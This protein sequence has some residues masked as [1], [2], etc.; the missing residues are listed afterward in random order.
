MNDLNK[1]N[2]P[3]SPFDDSVFRMLVEH[4]S[5]ITMTMDARGLILYVNPAVR[6]LLGYEPGDLIGASGFEIIH[7][8][9]RAGLERTFQ[10]MVENPGRRTTVRHRINTKRGDWRVFETRVGNF[11][12]HPPISAV[13]CN[14][15]DITEQVEALDAMRRQEELMNQAQSVARLGSWNLDLRT[16]RMTWSKEMYRIFGFEPMPDPAPMD[17]AMQRVHPRDVTRVAQSINKC[18]QSPGKQSFEYRIL[19]PGGA[20][21]IV[22][23]GNQSEPGPHGAPVSMHGTL[24][25]ITELKQAESEKQ[26]LQEQ[27][28]HIQKL[29]AVGTLAGG[30]AHEFNNMLAVIMGNASL[31]LQDPDAA[32]A[33]QEELEEIIKASERSRDLA[34]KLLTFARRDKINVQNMPV[35]E[36][37]GDFAA[38]IEHSFPHNIQVHWTAPDDLR[39]SADVSQMRQVLLNLCN[40]ACDAMPQGGI[41]SIL[42]ADIQIF[43]KEAEPL[44]GLC[45]GR[46]CFITVRDSGMGIPS[47]IRDKIF[48][49]FFTTKGVG[50][51][52][53]LGLSIAHG[54]VQNHN[55]RMFVDN[56][57][58][59]G[60][61]VAFCLPAADDATTP[62]APPAPRPAANKTVLVVDDQPI[63][64]TLA[65]RIL[66]RDRFLVLT[67][68]TGAEAIEVFKH[69][70]GSIDLVL[71]DL[72][73]PDLDGEDVCDALL[74][75]DPGAAVLLCSGATQSQRC[76]DMLRKGGIAGLLKKPFTMESLIEAVRS[77][78]A[79]IARAT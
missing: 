26:A 74:D 30:I 37:L 47:S 40:N 67:A 49:P 63:M 2:T 6:Q 35:K 79:R 68:G 13:I 5:D 42:A 41:L 24:Q 60:A 18:L 72:L 3:Q 31:L 69:M 78:L 28:Y 33:G 17:Q 8:D 10:E 4:S 15:T 1:R 22:L 19:L 53:G 27:L 64:L 21:R 55:G 56:H 77:A 23:A 48:D 76:H 36:L 46:Y 7:P 34:M 66:E 65:R 45:P 75:I 39:I 9:D 70:H 61:A 38:M 71:L 14:S 43:E 57:D 58:G 29:D 62:L 16:G 73:M 32:A 12:D 54:I 51:G 44:A 20:E 59:P 11:L 50:R 25:D 52:T